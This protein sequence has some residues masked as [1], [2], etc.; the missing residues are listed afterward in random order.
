MQILLTRKQEVVLETIRDHYLEKGYAPSLG[1]LQMML[2]INSKRGVVNHL[3]ALE[4]KGFIIRTSNARGI[5][6]V[7]EEEYEYLIGI[8]I[9]GYA[10]A[11]RPLASA[12]E[13]NIGTLKVDKKLVG[14]KEDLFALVVSGDSM[15]E[16]EIN[17]KKLT[18]GSFI[19]V[20]KN[21]EVVDGDTV[22]AV[23]DNSA[24]VKSIKKDI[25][26]IILYPVSSNPIHTPIYLDE[27]SQS[28]INGKVIQ[29]L[30]NPTYKG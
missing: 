15:N 8:P 17:G 9:L 22:V 1:E 24:T 21:E 6:I 5:T 25:N 30:D 27:F 19:I 28:L 12:V 11:G 7:E 23:L 3:N 10:N 29:V 13:D 16:R 20:S 4:K 14:N 26:S 18:D 2:H